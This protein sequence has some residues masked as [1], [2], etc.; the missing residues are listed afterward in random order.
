M[1]CRAGNLTL[2]DYYMSMSMNI[3]ICYDIDEFI[4]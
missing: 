3:S 4:S 1:R 2:Y